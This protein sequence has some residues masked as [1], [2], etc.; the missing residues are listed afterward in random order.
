MHIRVRKPDE[1][2]VRTRQVELGEPREQ[3]KTDLESHGGLLLL[4]GL[5]IYQRGSLHSVLLSTRAASSAS[6]E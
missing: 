2:L 5:Q 4:L 3:K 1:D 6:L